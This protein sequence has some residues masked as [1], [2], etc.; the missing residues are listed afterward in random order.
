[1]VAR[2]E[3]RSPALIAARV[4][5]SLAA[6]AAAVSTLRP[7]ATNPIASIGPKQS[8]ANSLTWPRPWSTST[9]APEASCSCSRPAYWATRSACTAGGRVDHLLRAVDLGGQVHAGHERRPGLGVLEGLT[10]QREGLRELVDHV[11]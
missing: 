1:M 10:H 2:Q 9:Q 6:R 8:G 5:G 7:A 11:F 4:A 3:S